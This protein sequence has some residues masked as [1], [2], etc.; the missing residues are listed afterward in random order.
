[1]TTKRK[2]GKD[3]QAVIMISKNK[4]GDPTKKKKSSPK[5]ERKWGDK[6]MD[7]GDTDVM[8]GMTRQ[9]KGAEKRSKTT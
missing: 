1:M 3:H 9:S 6:S 2:G 7:D 5:E 4:N 8:E